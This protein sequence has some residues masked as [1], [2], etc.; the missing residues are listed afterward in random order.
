MAII[1]HQDAIL[2]QDDSRKLTSQLN[3]V[4]AIEVYRYIHG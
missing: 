1:V 4:E 2:K 3:P